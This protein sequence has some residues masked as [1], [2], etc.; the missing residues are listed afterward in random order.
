MNHDCPMPDRQAQ[1]EAEPVGGNAI[2]AKQASQLFLGIAWAFVLNRQLVSAHANA[3]FINAMHLPTSS[4]ESPAPLFIF[5]HGQ[6]RVPLVAQQLKHSFDRCIALA[7][8]HVGSIV[9]LAVLDM[10]MRD[11]AVAF[12][13]E[14]QRI[15]V[16]PYIMAD[17][18]ID[19]VIVGHGERLLEA[20]IGGDGKSRYCVV[21]PVGSYR[22]SE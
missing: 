22:R 11:S 14:R 6:N 10:E 4:T 20:R 8:R 21:K 5:D 17:I 12:F 9:A 7:H 1:A 16:R 13:D 2:E 18:E 3:A 19:P 15:T